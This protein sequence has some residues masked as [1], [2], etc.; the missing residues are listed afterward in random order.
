MCIPAVCIPGMTVKYR[1]CYATNLIISTRMGKREEKESII[2]KKFTQKKKN[3]KGFSLVELIVVIAI[4]AVLMAVLVPTLVR[5]VEKSRVQTDKSAL[6]EVRQSVITALA[7][8]K[9]ID[10]KPSTTGAKVDADGKIKIADLFGTEAADK[11]LATEVEATI[12]A[13]TVALKSSMSDDAVVRLSFDTR[14]GQVTLGVVD[15]KSVV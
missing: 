1:S 4:M 14:K 15:R 12:G 8:E 6:A 13:S 2:M 5:N 9:F 10:A 3:N 11:A 7:Q